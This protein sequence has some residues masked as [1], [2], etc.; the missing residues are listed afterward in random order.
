MA[1][2]KDLI[3]MFPAGGQSRLLVLVC[4]APCCCAVVEALAKSC[5]ATFFFYAPNIF[6]RAEYE[7]RKAEVLR[8]CAHYGAEVVD[9]DSPPE[10]WERVAAGMEDEPERGMRCGA[11]FLLRMA[12]AAEY[13][14]ANRFAAF[15]STL[16]FSRHKN[17]AQA[18]EAGRLASRRFGVPY[19]A[20]DFRKSGGE[21]RSRGIIR[22]LGIYEQDY[23]GCRISLAK[24]RARV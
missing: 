12:R 19:V 8:V 24:R 6:P 1:A 16:G 18:D 23:C 21:A 22:E 7:R 20:A 17:P 10:D 3:N 15:A 14:S 13:A 5:A 9:C 11:C 2:C 4:C